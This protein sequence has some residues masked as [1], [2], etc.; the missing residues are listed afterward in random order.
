MK[1]DNSTIKFI[2]LAFLILGFILYLIY[3]YY[4]EEPVKQTTEPRQEFKAYKAES[5]VKNT[6]SVGT[7]I[8]FLLVLF[9]FITGVVVMSI[10][11]ILFKENKQEAR[12][13][14]VGA[15]FA[16]YPFLLRQY[17]KWKDNKNGQGKT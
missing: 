14:G 4:Y 11:L 3:K 6:V 13:S 2:L 17:K 5:D 9:S 10:F 8:K 12:I 7:G 15:I 1:I 16:T